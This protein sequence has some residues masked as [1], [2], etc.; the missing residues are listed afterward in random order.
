MGYG[1]EFE[2]VEFVGINSYPIP[3]HE[4]I[5]QESFKTPR[6]IAAGKGLFCHPQVNGKPVSP[7]EAF[8]RR[9][10]DCRTSGMCRV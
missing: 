6:E 9:R 8:E 4:I 5:G 10:L 2:L 1:C 7:H 3:S